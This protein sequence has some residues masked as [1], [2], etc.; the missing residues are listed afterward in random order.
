MYG[1]P[2]NT[3]INQPTE[4]TVMLNPKY[5]EEEFHHYAREV[6]PYRR[7]VSGVLEQ[8]TDLRFNLQE[9]ISEA[10][11]EQMTELSDLCAK[12]D[13]SCLAEDKTAAFDYINKIG[14]AYWKEAEEIAAERKA[15][16]VF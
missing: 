2:Y 1:N 4:R 7:M 15:G 16:H 6:I 5:H 13:Q 11:K 10:T 3:H 8:T 12:A 14:K 9:T